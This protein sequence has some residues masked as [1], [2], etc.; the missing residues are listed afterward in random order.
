MT[1]NAKMKEFYKAQIR[2]FDETRKEA[3][4]GVNRLTINSEIEVRL[5]ASDTNQVV[6]HIQGNGWKSNILFSI[7]R[8]KD[9]IKLYVKKKDINTLKEIRSMS[10]YSDSNFIL[11]IQIP[12]KKFEEIYIKIQNAWI[13]VKSSVRANKISINNKNGTIIIEDPE[14]KKFKIESQ[15]GYTTI[16]LKA[17]NNIDVDLHSKN[18]NIDLSI[19][20]IGKSEVLVKAQNGDYKNH[21]KLKGKYTLTG[22]I[23]SK[24]GDIKIF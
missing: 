18:G 3:V 19:D 7:E 6:S 16:N 9:E 1:I 12:K 5:S 14:T 11:E 20:N 10:V 21:L 17:K 8:V 22:E 4:D 24:N 23:L 15:N 13:K 2:D